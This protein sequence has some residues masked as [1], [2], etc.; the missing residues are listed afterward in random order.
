MQPPTLSK[1]RPPSKRPPSSRLLSSSV[2]PSAHPTPLPPG[3]Q[4]PRALL[5]ALG[6]SFKPTEGVEL[7]DTPPLHVD[8]PA[9]GLDAAGEAQAKE[10]DAERDGGGAG[11]GTGDEETQAPPFVPFPSAADPQDGAGAAQPAPW[12]SPHMPREDDFFSSSTATER[13]GAPTGQEP[14]IQAGLGLDAASLREKSREE[15]EAMLHEADRLIREREEEFVVFT[16]AGEGLLA[17]YQHL[18]S[19]HD[20]LLA[21]STDS[22]TSSTPTRSSRLST[23]SRT[24][25]VVEGSSGNRRPWRTSLGFAPPSSR[26]ASGSSHHRRTSSTF[27]AVRTDGEAAFTTPSSPILQRNRVASQFTPNTSPT[28]TRSRFASSSSIV[29][30]AGP[31]SNALFSPSHAAAEVT[32]LNQANY[33]LTVQLSELEAASEQ[34]ERDGRRKLRRLERELQALKDDLERVEQRNATLEM[35][36]TVARD[37][38]NQLARSVRAAPPVQ[39]DETPEVEEGFGE[40]DDDTP[41]HQF[42]GRLWKD[43]LAAFEA[44]DAAR[45][46]DEAGTDDDPFAMHDTP[47]RFTSGDKAFLSPRRLP[48]NG[49]SPFPFSSQHFTASRSVS[50]SSLV[51]LP[52][53]VE[54]DPALE[55]EQD[56]LLDQLMAKIDDLRE[57]NDEIVAEREALVEKLEQAQYEVVEWK[58]RC[59]ELE[60]EVVQQRLVAWDGP[61]AAIGWKSDDDA[62]ADSDAPARDVARRRG[63]RSTLQARSSRHRTITDL[64]RNSSTSATDPSELSASA[65]LTPVTSPTATREKLTLDSE[66]GGEWLDGDSFR[67]EEEDDDD[68]CAFADTSNL[69][70]IV[71]ALD[72]QDS[73]ADAV[74]GGSAPSDAYDSSVEHQPP[75]TT[76]DDLLSSGAFRHAGP[77]ATGPEAYDELAQA[78]AALAPAWADDEREFAALPAPS[79]RRAITAGEGTEDRLPAY[80]GSGKGGE[81]RRR[82]EKK[83]GSKSKSR[84]G[85][86]QL[87]LFQLPFMDYDHNFDGAADDGEGEGEGDVTTTLSRRD[88]ALQRLGAEA[89]S[90]FNSLRALPP[91]SLADRDEDGDEDDDATSVS[92]A[93]YDVLD[94]AGRSTDYYPLTLRARYRPSMLATMFSDR[95]VRHVITFVTWVRFLLLLSMA[96]VFSIWQG[97]KKT[98]GLLDGQRRLR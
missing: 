32:T 93:D 68:A 47:S 28:N 15:L 17:E 19:R 62:D 14:E 78:A 7:P 79:Q 40:G 63:R 73:L 61:R 3:S 13:V 81:L 44:E 26:L 88:L 51:P 92:S 56:A 77:A 97:P 86:K 84:G 35:E 33:S 10:W 16:T 67:A 87:Q 66:L 22:N 36:A 83:G 41:T 75:V 2:P 49:F 12:T 71:H 57:V 59:E 74:V 39:R 29:S 45:L 18:R 72:S 58:E 70:A 46:D 37:R 64:S 11:A 9:G 82:K 6:P 98:L 5:P 21:R 96:V 27:S 90:R 34:S 30:L 76:A 85:K 43:R 42:D 24:S 20:S 69:S 38:E 1:P 25:P 23:S 52:A 4:S 54:L 48:G 31:P 95:A 60:D 80:G 53:A 50:T 91:A 89:S 94:S 55:A 8:W 65:S